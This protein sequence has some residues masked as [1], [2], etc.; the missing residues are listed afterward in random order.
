MTD[1]TNARDLRAAPASLL[2][3]ERGIAFTEYLLLVIVV[4]ILVSASLLAVGVPI[5]RAFRFSQI[6]LGA[7]VP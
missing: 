1:E 4:G 2:E 6:V 5:F 3:D 7:P